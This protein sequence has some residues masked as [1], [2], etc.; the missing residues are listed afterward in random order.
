MHENAVFL[1]LDA[2]GSCCITK[3]GHLVRSTVLGGLNKW[4]N[5]CSQNAP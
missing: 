1:P 2:M 4:Q 5:F 3:Q